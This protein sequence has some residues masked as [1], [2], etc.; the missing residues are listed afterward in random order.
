MTNDMENLQNALYLDNEWWLPQG[1]GW[2][3]VKRKGV[4]VW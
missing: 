2:G 4:K 1:Q 3:R